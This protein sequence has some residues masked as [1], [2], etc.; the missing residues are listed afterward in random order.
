MSVPLNPAEPVEFQPRPDGPKLFL[1]VPEVHERPTWR[2]EIRRMKGR[3]WSHLD[4]AESLKAG[5]DAVLKTP[6][7]TDAERE[8]RERWLGYVEEYKADIRAALD[9]WAAEKSDE[10]DKQ[11][12]E[13]V[14]M[15]PELEAVGEHIAAE[16]EPF[17]DRLSDNESF[18]EISGMAGFKLYCVGWEGEKL[19]EFH[20]GRNGPDQNLM[21][22]LQPGDYVALSFKIDSLF[23][24]DEQQAK[25]S[26]SESGA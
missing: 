24:P 1:R 4:L 12:R 3:Y 25:N 13:A 19:P 21:R 11:W 7:E 8:E 14:K 22:Y 6:D 2:K 18:R 15:R 9:R 20:R 26:G 5:I 16:Y 23:G 10:A 17:N